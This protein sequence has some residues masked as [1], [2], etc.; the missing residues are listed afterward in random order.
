MHAAQSPLPPQGQPGVPGG[1]A[2]PGVAG[3]PRMGA[4]PQ[5]PRPDLLGAFLAGFC[6]NFFSN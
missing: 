3:T 1:G 2:A 5:M 6:A 4:Q